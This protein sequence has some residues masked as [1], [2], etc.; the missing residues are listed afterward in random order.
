MSES[1]RVESLDALKEFKAALVTFGADALEA[2]AAAEAQI[3]RALD[4]LEQQLKHWQ[5][6]L[7]RRQEELVRAKAELAQKRW[8]HR[9]SRGPGMTDAELAVRHAEQRVREAEAKIQTTRRWLL[10]LPREVAEY[11]GPARRLGGWLEADLKIGTA[12][13]DR[14]IG[15]LE[16]YLA[17]PAPP[18]EPAEAAPAEGQP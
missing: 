15:A 3:Q 11:R 4:G 1:A 10:H 18:P 8:G 9:D 16:A 2:L 13:L 17:P 6:E 7:R 14:R 5:A 12:L